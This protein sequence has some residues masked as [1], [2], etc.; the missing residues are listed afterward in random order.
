MSRLVQRRA[1]PA[2][3]CHG[4]CR[5]KLKKVARREIFLS[6][7]AQGGVQKVAPPNKARNKT[8]KT[9][10]VGAIGLFSHCAQFRCAV[11]ITTHPTRII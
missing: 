2:I 11:L 10:E 8:G 4:A 1:K 9:L 6:R 5:G 3:I 7:V